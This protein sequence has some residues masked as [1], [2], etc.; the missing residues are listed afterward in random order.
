M[1]ARDLTCWA[2]CLV[3]EPGDRITVK[4]NPPGGGATDTRDYIVQRIDA[5]VNLADPVRSVF[6]FQLWP[7]DARNWLLMDDATFGRVD[8]NKV[9][10]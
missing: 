3:R 4:Q 2:A 7:C 9:G 8:F 6:S 1:P 5:D 10:A